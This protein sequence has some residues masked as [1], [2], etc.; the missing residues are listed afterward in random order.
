M[1]VKEHEARVFEAVRDTIHYRQFW[2]DQKTISED[3]E[4]LAA[5]VGCLPISQI[6]CCLK[7]P[8][9]EEEKIRQ[10]MAGMSESAYCINLRGTISQ[11][12]A[13]IEGLRHFAR[14]KTISLEFLAEIPFTDKRDLMLAILGKNPEINIEPFYLNRLEVESLEGIFEAAGFRP[15]PYSRTWEPLNHYPMGKEDPMGGGAAAAVDEPSMVKKKL[16]LLHT[17]E[18]WYSR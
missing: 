9:I 12:L 2:L 15:R 10:V 8:G 5:H 6:Y 7:D 13:A 16:L 18:E 11:S 4:F 17:A 1:A 14:F 3:P